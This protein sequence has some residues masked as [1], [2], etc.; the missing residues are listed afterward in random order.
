MLRKRYVPNRAFL[1]CLWLEVNTH[2]KDE[3]VQ[4]STQKT[5]VSGG[6]FSEKQKR[7]RQIIIVAVAV[8]LII[9]ALAVYLLF[10]SKKP[11]SDVTDPRPSEPVSM[12]TQAETEQRLKARYHVSIEDV[13]AGKLDID[14]ISDFDK[15]VTLSDILIVNE[16]NDKALQAYLRAE[17][18]GSETQ[19]NIS[20]Y[21]KLIG[22]AAL[23]NNKAELTRAVDKTIE[24]IK[25]SDLSEGEKNY[26]INRLETKYK[27]APEQS[28]EGAE[29]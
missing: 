17:K 9:L 1:I 11:Y 13:K 27:N 10:F 8:L 16:M 25:A 22:V 23:N 3:P 4:T 7:R 24:L 29:Q 6:S 21:D 15:L 18:Q 26:N 28:N 20:F 19:K 2:H 5:P 14:K 12:L